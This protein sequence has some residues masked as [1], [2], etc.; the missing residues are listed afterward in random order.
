MGA[1]II[2]H[3]QEE[4][5]FTFNPNNYNNGR[6][7]LYTNL[8]K[9]LKEEGKAKI[10]CLE[11]EDYKEIA[12]ST[13]FDAAVTLNF[14]K[15]LEGKLS[16]ASLIFHDTDKF[17][18]SFMNY[19]V[20]EVLYN[21]NR[22][23]ERECK[24]PEFE[25]FAEFNLNRHLYLLVPGK[26]AGI[27][28][29]RMYKHKDITRKDSAKEICENEEIPYPPTITELHKKK[30]GIFGLIGRFLG[31]KI[32]LK[33]IF[34]AN[35]RGIYRITSKE[36]FEEFIENKPEIEKYIAQK[37]IKIP[38][39]IA[40]HFRILSFG[41][42][43]IASGIQYNTNF[44]YVTNGEGSRILP[45]M[46]PNSDRKHSKIEKEIFSAY[47]LKSRET[48]KSIMEIGMK[49]AKQ[50]SDNGFQLNGIDVIRSKEGKDMLIDVNP[51]PG[52][53]I[54]NACYGKSDHCPAKELVNM[55]AEVISTYF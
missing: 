16:K 52:I 34:K 33:H 41:K 12:R 43:I 13:K 55:T 15:K 38:T 1:S 14:N 6:G 27:R 18:D 36:D 48:P 20:E 22:K 37:E 24:N 31:W 29:P 17:K 51:L 54:V 49:A 32:Y 42:Q 7:A 5:L 53:G 40:S 28:V 3:K 26:T 4:V 46:G 9:K 10:S 2:P 30:L 39:K 8:A 35:G 21:N 19:V 45:L 47:C 25:K 50:A 23:L 11:K 44:E